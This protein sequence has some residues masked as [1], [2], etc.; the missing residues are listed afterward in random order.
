MNKDK[1][2]E[3]AELEAKLIELKKKS[4]NK[5]LNNTW[6][7]YVGHFKNVKEHDLFIIYRTKGNNGYGLDSR[8]EWLD[9]SSWTFT[10]KPE[11]WEEASMD[12]VTKM[13]LY[14][15][16]KRGFIEDVTYS[17][18]NGTA[19]KVRYNPKTYIAVDGSISLECGSGDGFIYSNGKWGTVTK[20]LTF[21][22][23]SKKM[24]CLIDMQNKNYKFGCHP[25]R[26]I[27]DF[28]TSVSYLSELGVEGL[29]HPEIGDFHLTELIEIIKDIRKFE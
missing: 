25:F 27:S 12:E 15:A 26:P 16:K 2:A 6:Y 13:L 9:D 28:I 19:C 21:K 11:D 4:T 5:L 23:G 18:I 22:V 1:K 24:N 7:K 10:S 20:F 29:Y 14:E 17:N 8:K 3:I